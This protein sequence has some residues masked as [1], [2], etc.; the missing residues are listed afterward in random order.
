MVLSYGIKNIFLKY[1]NRGHQNYFLRHKN[2]VYPIWSRLIKIM[3]IQKGWIFKL[4]I[5]FKFFYFSQKQF[6]LRRKYIDI[7]LFIFIFSIETFIIKISSSPILSKKINYE[8]RIMCALLI[9]IAGFLYLL[10]SIFQF[11]SLIMQLKIFHQM[12]LKLHFVKLN[13]CTHFR[14]AYFIKISL[15]RLYDIGHTQTV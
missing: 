11:V 12:Y 9:V 8:Y 3:V 15:L 4:G 2:N 10:Y 13:I 7:L 14:L 1:F 6:Y 5:V